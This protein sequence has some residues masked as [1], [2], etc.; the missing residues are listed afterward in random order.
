MRRAKAR[1]RRLRHSDAPPRK[2]ELC[3]RAPIIAL[4]FGLALHGRVEIIPL[5]V[6]ILGP[7]TS[8]GEDM[9]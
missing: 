5:G 2:L 1:L 6:S 9:A 4:I 7:K 3:E 8:T